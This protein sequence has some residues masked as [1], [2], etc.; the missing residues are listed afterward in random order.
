MN[1]IFFGKKN[2]GQEDYSNAYLPIFLPQKSS[3]QTPTLR[4]KLPI[5]LICLA[6]MVASSLR[7]DDALASH[8]QFL[9]EHCGKC[10][11]GEKPKGGFDLKSLSHLFADA[12][13][14][15]H[16]L[17]VMEQ[18]ETG[19]MPPETKP[20]PPATQVKALTAWIRQTAAQS[21]D[22]RVVMRRLNRAEY[23]NTVRDLLGV[24]VDLADLL[25]PDT[26]TNGFDNNAESLHTSS[27]LLRSYLD[28]ADRVLDE[29][30]V[31]E[32]KP[33]QVKKRF[34]IKD[35]SSVKR[36]GSVY[37]FLEDG[38]AIFA[39]WES[40]NIRVTMW[41][42]RSPFRGKYRFRI[43]AYGF[44]SQ[45]KPVKFHVTAGTF[46]EVTEER[47]LDYY[48]VPADKPTEIEF[49]AQLEPEN[50]IRI[51][52]DDLPATPPMVEKI[53]ADKY[54]GPGLVVQW[55][56]AEG[57]LMDSWP[58]ASHVALFGDLEQ[59]KMPK[60]DDPDWREVVSND[61]LPD[62]ER[63][64]RQFARRAFRRPVMEEDI[65][66]IL[67][68]VRQRLEAGYTFEQAVRVGL[69]AVLVSPQF[70]F[71]HEKSPQEGGKL[72]DFALASR[73]SYFLWSSMPDEELFRLASD[74]KLHQPAVLRQQVERLLKDDKAAAFTR[75]FTGQWLSLRAIDAT[76]PD[77]T[78]YPEYDDSLKSAMLKETN[79]FFNEVLTQDL[80]LTSFVASD[81]TFLNERL[82]KHYGI[83]GVEG[84]EMRRVIL[85]AG[86]HRGGV[87]TMGSVLKVTANGT[88]TSPVLRGSWVLERILGTPPAKPPVDVEAI[89]PDIRGAT[90]I[91]EQLA[92]HRDV[93]ACA[94]CHKKIDPPGF[95]LESFDVIGGWRE[96]YRSLTKY[97][98]RD[99]QGRRVRPGPPV[100]PSDVLT[101]GR[102][103]RDID[104]FKQL[105]LA[106]KDQLARNLAEKL[107]AYAT[108]AEPTPLDRPQIESI[109]QRTRENK[110]GFR[111]LIHEIVQSSLF[112]TK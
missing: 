43:S 42:F 81:F 89:E 17:S 34:H 24:E 7:A 74:Q 1:S 10:H 12:D 44:Q 50:R 47:L 69:K 35:E 18:I 73:L 77:R 39:V 31:N 25:P 41:N 104:E 111:S 33:W 21:G 79:L 23:A 106:D 53:G 85:S 14:R 59:K 27:Y 38:V 5:P 61:P 102:R 62:A 28:A 54:D 95:A 65:Q 93:E 80:P 67:A 68:R 84:M 78:L 58:P 75:E 6:I 92:K 98:E 64:L 22:G 29:A 37:R 112:Q 52:A 2:E 48:S 101:D 91:R 11:T 13:S 94:G 60:D 55:V 82:A 49:T 107:L 45:G 3:C 66:P 96:H 40:A 15:R 19:E 97:G 9:N 8:R 103:F 20:R 70:L 72:D 4:M 46:K 16:W 51:I 99:S 87:M 83:P 26:S 108:G 71:F 88:T 30:I 56:D 57:P 36:P 90:T 63:I 105:L 32:S 110:N 100:D 76:M 86:S 109:I